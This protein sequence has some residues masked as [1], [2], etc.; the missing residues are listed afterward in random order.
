MNVAITRAKRKELFLE[1]MLFLEDGKTED[2]MLRDL[3]KS[4]TGKAL[5]G[6]RRDKMKVSFETQIQ[7]YVLI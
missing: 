7:I 1:S 6:P 4:H 2:S 3:A 5:F